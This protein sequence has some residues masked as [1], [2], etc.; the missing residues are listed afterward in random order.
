MGFLDFNDNEEL[1]WIIIIV[2]IL[3]FLFNERD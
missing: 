2:V 3:L 1:L